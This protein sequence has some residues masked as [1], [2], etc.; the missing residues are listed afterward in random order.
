MSNTARRRPRLVTQ[1]LAA[2]VGVLVVAAVVATLVA[3]TVGPSLF[4]EHLQRA[5]MSG[6]GEMSVH[7]EEAFTSTGLITLVVALGAALAVATGATVLLARQVTQPLGALHEAA[8]QVAGGGYNDATRL[9]TSGPAEF[10]DVTTAFVQMATRLQSVEQVRQ[11]MLSDLAHE[12]RTPLATLTVYLDAVDDHVAAL[13]E[14]TTS[15]LRDQVIRLERL[16][17]DINTVSRAEEDPLHMTT[18]DIAELTRTLVESFDKPGTDHRIRVTTPGPSVRIPGDR[19]RLTQVLTNLVDNALRHAGPTGQVEV[20][21]RHCEGQAV[22]TVADD[23]DGIP[24]GALP[25]IFERFYRTDT[26]RDRA[27]GGAGIGLAICSALV[28]AHHGTIT[29]RSPGPAQGATFTVTLP[30]QISMKTPSNRESN[31]GTG[32]AQWTSRPSHVTPT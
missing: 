17:R 10:A 29:A 28:R 13:D 22:I 11:Q 32:D 6:T 12:M 24:A 8:R 14:G 31:P 2:Q 7:V 15:V 19:D 18:L 1:L 27:H 5:G 23:G 4:H 30:A 3:V 20:T 26:A 21:V 9:H 25:H 16:V